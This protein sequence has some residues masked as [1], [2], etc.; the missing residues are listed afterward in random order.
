MEE[1]PSV[2]SSKVD[3]NDPGTY[4]DAWS[5]AACLADSGLKIVDNVLSYAKTGVGKPGQKEQSLFIASTAMAYAVWEN[6]VEQVAI[7]LVTVLSDGVDPEQ[8]P[9]KPR[10]EIAKADAWTLAVHPGWRARWAEIVATR[11]VGSS[12][13]YGL[14][15]ANT[16]QVRKLFDL[17]GIDAFGGLDTSM[18]DRLDQLVKDRGTIVHTAQ[19][20]SKTFRKADAVGWWDFVS[21]LYEAFDQSLRCQGEVLLGEAPW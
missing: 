13:D 3:P 5:E 4:V 20:P 7:E 21:E 17:V 14:N 2:E 1:T 18:T 19:P 12:S 15:T 16:A 10:Q 8:V 9:E 6:Y 11:A